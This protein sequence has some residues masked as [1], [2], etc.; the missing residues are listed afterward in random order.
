MSNN[1]I[2]QKVKIENFRSYKYFVQEFCDKPVVLITG[3]NG[4]G[5]TTLI[6]AIEW[7][8]TGDI[9]RISNSYKKRNTTQPEK[10]RLENLKGQIK[11]R[12]S[13]SD[14]KI[15]VEIFFKCNDIEFSVWRE[16]VADNLL[17]VTSLN[18][19]EGI[20]EGL[21]KVIGDL[22]NENFYPYFV[23][24]N[25]KAYDFLRT[26]RKD[27][28]ELFRDF[29]QN[30]DYVDGIIS[31]I[32]AIETI[33]KNKQTDMQAE[34]TKADELIVKYSKEISE[35]KNE[36]ITADYPDIIFYEGEN[37]N[38]VNLTDDQ[39]TNQIENI[40]VVGCNESI[41]LI[42]ELL[43]RKNVT[44]KKESIDKLIK[45][46]D[47]NREVVLSIIKRKFYDPSV[48][49]KFTEER[50]SIEN[51]I[52]ETL[53]LNDYT[54]IQKFANEKHEEFS[55]SV[56]LNHTI[57]K[58]SDIETEKNNLEK[59]IQIMQ[60]GNNIIA[61][62][63][64]LVKYR[65]AFIEYRQEGNNFCP[66]CG[67]KE[68]FSSFANK[69]DIAITAEMY[70]KQANDRILQIKERHK[71]ILVD[72]DQI[73]NKTK[74]DIN[75]IYKDKYAQVDLI[76]T[77]ATNLNMKYSAFFDEYNKLGL[78]IDEQIKEHLTTEKLLCDSII[79]KRLSFD[80][81]KE[82]LTKLMMYYGVSDISE[83]NLSDILSNLM[84]KQSDSLKCLGFDY[85]SFQQK[86]NYLKRLLENQRYLN[87]TNEIKK[88]LTEK[89]KIESN[90]KLANGEKEELH[91]I[92]TEINKVRKD[93][94]IKE[95]EYVGPYIYKVFV[96]IIKHSNINGITVKRDNSQ[97]GGMVL[98]DDKGL[99][100]M[101]TLSQGQLGV[102]MLAYFFANAMR[103][104]DRSSFKTFFIDDITASLDDLNILAFLDMIK[105]I[106]CDNKKIMNQIF[107]S[108]C[109]S[110]VE[111][112]FIHKLNSMN[113]DYINLKFDSYAKVV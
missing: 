101:N 36:I 90:L 32:Q 97:N 99:N 108:T 35:L 6:D 102:L 77:E 61:A 31:D 41:R 113:I 78:Q 33:A 68:T 83:N 39:I 37:I 89:E 62:L 52:S 46:F 22:S 12:E 65:D 106:L 16:Q 98:V 21:K 23:C 38:P 42:N 70:V 5:K 25:N 85:A 13:T 11:N 8:L 44:K 73:L 57:L 66:L 2:I 111:K 59:N 96:K 3:P 14:E 64:D 56:D 107:F 91:R 110:D 112:L 84:I 24:D 82:Y 27:V 75:D 50:K 71:Q 28:L 1:L 74:E 81:L 103:N 20:S 54:S 60:E 86:L 17:E 45:E 95:L 43:E 34:L 53:K 92:Q 72:Y 67:S 49:S 51:R 15:R 63:S 80:E 58:L 55:E 104:N 40:L 105:Y 48:L 109:N 18:F 4:Y 88:L 100:L 30:N 7:G 9:S 76:N 26:P 94:E 93:F 29:L 47:E 79:R 87:M 19:S 69:D 10:D